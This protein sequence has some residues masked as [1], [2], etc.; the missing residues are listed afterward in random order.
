MKKKVALILAGSGRAD[1]SEI[2]ET[3]LALLSLSQQNAE[4]QA[5]APNIA[6]AEVINHITGEKMNETRN[7]ITEAARIV[8]GNIK[9]IAEYTPTDFDALLIPGGFGVAKNL[10]SFAFEGEKMTVNPDVEK[11]VKETFNAK[12]PIGALCIAPIILS[13]VLSG[14]TLTFGQDATTA[15]IAK[16]W[17]NTPTITNEGEITVDITNKIVTTPCYM[18]SESSIAEV[19]TGIN[20][21]VVKLLELA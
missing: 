1:G 18:L 21:L 5:F 15:Q 16:T 2:H 17:G 9:D 19:Y 20:K 11:A 7:V 14:I 6:Q 10:C 4:I 12:K 13:K 3:T 8:R